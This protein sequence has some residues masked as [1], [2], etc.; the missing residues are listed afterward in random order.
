MNELSI[1]EILNNCCGKTENNKPKTIL[2]CTLDKWD[3]SKENP[4][5]KTLKTLNITSA[6]LDMKPINEKFF[7][8][9]L[10][11][12]S[13]SNFELRNLWTLVNKQ[14]QQLNDKNDNLTVLRFTFVPIDYK[15]YYVDAVA[16]IFY[17]LQGYD[18]NKPCNCLRILFEAENVSF[19]YSN[20]IDIE[21]IKAEVELEYQENLQKETNQDFNSSIHVY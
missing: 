9:D 8:I 4:T 10:D 17:S 13:N 20:E 3:F 18:I 1:F 16:P 19:Y 6:I 21:A 2:S 14:T 5:V 12:Q 15:G 7:M 11:F